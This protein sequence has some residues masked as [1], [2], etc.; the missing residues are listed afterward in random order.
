MQ[1]SKMFNRAKRGRGQKYVED[2]S[3]ALSSRELNNRTWTGKAKPKKDK[4]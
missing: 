2:K 1:K 3:R 4:A